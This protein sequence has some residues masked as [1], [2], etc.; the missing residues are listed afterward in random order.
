MPRLNTKLR[1]ELVKR[2]KQLCRD[3]DHD[4]EIMFGI[5]CDYVPEKADDAEFQSLARLHWD[6]YSIG[7]EDFWPEV[8]ARYWHERIVSYPWVLDRESVAGP[9]SEGGVDAL[10]D[11]L[12]TNVVQ[13]GN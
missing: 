5:L 13:D 7:I 4:F 8:F 10:A 9:I 1:Q 6:M 2:R 3:Q 12:V 11:L